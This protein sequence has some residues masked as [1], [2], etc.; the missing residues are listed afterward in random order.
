MRGAFATGLGAALA[1]ADQAGTRAFAFADQDDIWRRD[2]LA[3]SIAELEYH[4]NLLDA[5]SLD[6]SHKIILHLGGTYG[7]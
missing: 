1:L 2:K 7:D 3:R 5:F 6:K 4:A